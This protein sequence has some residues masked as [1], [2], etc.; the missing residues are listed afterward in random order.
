MLVPVM[1]LLSSLARY[2]TRS[3]TSTALPSL[4]KG[5]ALA[6]LVRTSGLVN[7]S[8][9]V[10]AIIPGSTAF[11]R[12]PLGPNALAMALVKVATAP[13]EVAYAEA[14]KPPPSLPACEEKLMIALPVG[15]RADT[16]LVVRKADFTFR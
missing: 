2:T 15:I 12:M 10:V 4:R 1:K 13:L 3:A 16:Y 9:K 5:V 14:P 11:T 6:T 8:W 7:V